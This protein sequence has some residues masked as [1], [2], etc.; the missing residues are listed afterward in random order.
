[1]SLSLLILS[2]VV[3]ANIDSTE[4]KIGDQTQ[5]HL[6]ATAAPS[7][8]VQFPKYG[9]TLIEGLEIVKQSP[10]DTIWQDN[11]NIT[12]KQ[13]LTLTAFKD[14]LFL[15][16]SIPFV[17]GTDT[18]YTDPLSLNIIQPFII[19]TADNAIT[20][21]KPIY[22]APVWWWG[23]MRWVL[24]AI[25]IIGI[26]VGLYY[27]IRFLHKRRT[28]Q[29]EPATIVEDT[30]PAEEI[31]L[32][33]LNVIK[34][35]KIWQQGRTKDYYTELTDT[36]RD[37]MARRFD[38]TTQENTSAEILAQ[39]K[40]LIGKDLFT[41]LKQALMLADLVKFAKWIP[42]TE[43]NEQA[44]RFAYRFVEQTTSVEQENSVDSTNNNDSNTTA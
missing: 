19:D 37:Y 36:L 7:E 40:Q 23:V 14:S 17:S 4:L 8:Q 11:G 3:S 29:K 26:A 12:F 39:I 6:S 18:I 42:Q 24:L 21:I 43:E 27:L 25:G 34:E 22:K 9:A 32:E 38:I 41:S 16:P 1:M 13:D 20:D 2:I 15:I 5:L 30:R 10:V 31:A 35:Q 28:Q 44:L 33:R